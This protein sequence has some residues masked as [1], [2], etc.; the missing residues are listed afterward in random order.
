MIH[1]VRGTQHADIPPVLCV[2]P[3]AVP[4]DYSAEERAAVAHLAKEGG[5]SSL[6][7]GRVAVTLST[8]DLKRLAS[9]I[10]T[11]R[12]ELYSVPVDWEGFDDAVVI[13]SKLKPFINKKMVEY[14]GEEEPSLVEHI[15]DKLKKH[16][17]AA[18][19]EQSL[20]QVLDEDAA[21]FVVKLWRM[22]LFEIKSHRAASGSS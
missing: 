15:L 18:E 3:C 14:L 21:V 12:D 10:P 16:T 1:A 13:D 22:L 9:S 2:S 11:T 7:S 19:I 6:S 8:E 20:V 4:I 5:G 17:A